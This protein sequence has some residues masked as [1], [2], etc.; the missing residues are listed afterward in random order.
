MLQVGVGWPERYFFLELKKG[1]WGSL[2]V[3]VRAQERNRWMAFSKGVPDSREVNE[4]TIRRWEEL[5]ETKRG[6]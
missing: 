6:W 2:S 5:R 1:N 4:G 3:S